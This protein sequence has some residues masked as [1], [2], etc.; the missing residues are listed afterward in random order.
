[1]HECQL[2][3]KKAGVGLARKIGMDEAARWFNAISKNG[4]ITCFDADSTCERNFLQEIHRQFEANALD[5]GVVFYEHPLVHTEIEQYELFLRYHVDSLRYSCFPFAFQTLG[6]CISVRSHIYQKHGG[7][8]TRKAGEDFYFL[9][10]IIPHCCFGEINTT[11][12]YP[13]PRRSDRVPFGTGVAVSKIASL[14]RYEVYSFKSFEDLRIL[15]QSVGKIYREESLDLPESIMQF[16]DDH[17]FEKALSSMR[18]NTASIQ[19]F[20]KR[21]Y[22]WWDAFRALKYVHYARDHYFPL[23]SLQEAIHSLNEAYWHLE[24]K[25]NEN[26]QLQQ[27]RNWDRAY[28]AKY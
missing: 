1:M 21:F 10:K 7:M 14:A 26:E 4:I 19:A 3:A 13:S 22:A 5:A 17:D 16:H 9:H 2:P 28:K 6:S 8:N 15:F 12:M 20:A 24:L 27:I 11:T 25:N 18:R 23:T